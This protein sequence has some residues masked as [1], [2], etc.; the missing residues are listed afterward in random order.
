MRALRIGAALAVWGWN[1]AAAAGPLPFL[2]RGELEGVSRH[3]QGQI[4]D[5]THNHGSDRRIWS[6]ALCQKRDLYVYLPPGFDPQQQYP[7][8]LWLHGFTQDEQSFLDFIAEPVDRAIVCGQLPPVIIAVPD[9]SLS[10]ESSFMSA[11]SFFMNSNAGRFEDFVMQDVWNF[12]MENFPIRPEREAHVIAGVS[13]G[14]GA[15]YNLAIKYRERFKTV[16]GIFPPVNLRWLDCH[17]KYMRKF[18]P[19]CWGWRTDYS[20]GHEVVGRFYVIITV[21][22]KQV[23]D[24]LYDRGAQTAIQISLENPIEMIDRLALREGELNMYIGYGGR[25]QFNIDAQVESFLYRARQRGLTIAVDYDPKGKHDAPTALRLF[26]CTIRWLAPL[27][28]AY[29]PAAVK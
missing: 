14:G 10:G 5:Y 29:A 26:P 28:A 20:H 24:D 8:I 12:V 18:D 7:F 16:V 11:G 19:G 2:H 25:D 4:V 3:I 17:C 9:G 1:S 22:L 21:R 15:A 27:I 23:L 6:A 13:M